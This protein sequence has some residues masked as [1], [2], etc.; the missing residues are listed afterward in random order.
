MG[1][2]RHFTKCGQGGGRMAIDMGHVQAVLENEGGGTIL[3][4]GNDTYGVL[5]AYDTCLCWWA[6]VITYLDQKE[7]DHAARSAD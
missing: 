2:I 1:V 4:T 5:E 7:A 6:D 3:V